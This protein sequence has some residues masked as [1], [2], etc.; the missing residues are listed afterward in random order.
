MLIEIRT[1]IQQSTSNLASNPPASELACRHPPPSLLLSLSPSPPIYS[2]LTSKPPA[3]EQVCKYP[4]PS[5]PLSLP[6]NLSSN[7]PASEQVCGYELAR[8]GLRDLLGRLCAAPPCCRDVCQTKTQEG[9]GAQPWY[10]YIMCGA[11]E[12]NQG[13]LDPHLLLTRTEREDLATIVG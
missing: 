5:L 9:A 4:S 11:K 13:R 1:G 2:N 10:R 3:S 6:H 12:V 7:P 8:L